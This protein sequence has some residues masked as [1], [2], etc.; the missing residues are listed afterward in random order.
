[1]PYDSERAGHLAL[2]RIA[3][4]PDVQEFLKGCVVRKPESEPQTGGSLAVRYVPQGIGQMPRFVIA[5]DGSYVPVPVENGFPGAEVGFVTAALVLLDVKRMQELAQERFPSPAA[6]RRTIYPASAELVLPGSNVQRKGTTGPKESFRRQIYE[7]WKQI[8]IEE[9][10]ESLLDTYH[11]LLHLHSK[12]AAA[13][14][15]PRCPYEDCQHPDQRLAIAQG[16]YV[17]SC[18]LQRPLYSTDALRIHEGF[19]PTGSCGEAYGEV[20]QV[21]ERLM[22]VNALRI[23]EKK[24]LLAVADQVAFVV[25]GPLAVFGHP[26]WLKDAIQAEIQ[27]I[28]QKVRQETG[29]DLL[30]LGVEKSGMFMEHLQR[31][32]TT[33]EGTPGAFPNGTAIL[34]TNDYIRRFIVISDTLRPY[35]DQTYFGRKFFYKTH[36]GARIVGVTP[37]LEPDHEDLSRAVPSQFPRLEDALLLLDVMTSSRYPD[38]AIPLVE[39][40]AQAAISLGVGVEV[41]KKL[42]E[43]I[44]RT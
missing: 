7:G 21:T 13:S 24:G 44:E 19:N 28:N 34:L 26:A 17:C 41:L 25:D 8:R 4:R 14:H 32:D 10:E 18:A 39:A 23:M 15:A 12:S 40:H 30:I 9:G 33:P 27:R 6:M 20:M 1:M 42:V 37:F 2:S 29:K 11:A 5:V 38:A 31:L 16:A 43:L 22:L 3:S 36:R 35:G